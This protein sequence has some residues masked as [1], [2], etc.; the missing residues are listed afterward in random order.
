[1]FLFDSTGGVLIGAGTPYVANI[2]LVGSNFYCYFSPV[3]LGP[4][5]VLDFEFE[6]VIFMI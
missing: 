2:G 1:M 4:D 5:E 6:V 3:D